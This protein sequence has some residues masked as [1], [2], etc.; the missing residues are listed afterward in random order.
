M[1]IKQFI[2]GLLTTALLA[3]SIPFT[4]MATEVEPTKSLEN[5]A[6]GKDGNSSVGGG[7]DWGNDLGRE[8]LRISLV[9]ADD[10]SK[11]VSIDGAGKEILRI[12]L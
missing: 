5:S 8:G 6:D 10:P 4:S 11:V 2:S 9:S 7:G 1:K 3:T 12:L